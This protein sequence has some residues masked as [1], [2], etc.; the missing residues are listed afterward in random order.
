VY[1][2]FERNICKRNGGG[3]GD[4]PRCSLCVCPMY[5][6]CTLPEQPVPNL[7]WKNTYFTDSVHCNLP[8]R[9]AAIDKR[10]EARARDLYS[11]HRL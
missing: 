11:D 1:F 3:G 6:L 10:Q 9:H 4:V 5:I 2:L 7:T 8:H